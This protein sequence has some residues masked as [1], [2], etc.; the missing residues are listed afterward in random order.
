MYD[1]GS[2][3]FKSRRPSNPSSKKASLQGSPDPLRLPGVE[4]E[5]VSGVGFALPPSPA[6]CQLVR[7]GLE[8]CKPVSRLR[9][10]WNVAVVV[11]FKSKCFKRGERTVERLPSQHKETRGGSWLKGRTLKNLES[12]QEA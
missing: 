5:T 7:G 4:S 10:S 1:V 9:Q 12:Y 11:V 3:V 2:M 6:H 8:S